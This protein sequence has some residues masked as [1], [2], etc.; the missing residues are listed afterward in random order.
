MN[1][2]TGL[3]KNDFRSSDKVQNNN[4]AQNNYQSINRLT[5]PNI[6]SSNGLDGMEMHK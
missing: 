1:K 6:A 2:W 5:K 3:A 4:R